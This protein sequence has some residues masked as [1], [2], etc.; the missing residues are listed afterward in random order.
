M[1]PV[2]YWTAFLYEWGISTSDG[3]VGPWMLI[4]CLSWAVLTTKHQDLNTEESVFELVHLWIVV[5][6]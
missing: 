6:Y 2:W 3:E 4:K 5:V 1:S